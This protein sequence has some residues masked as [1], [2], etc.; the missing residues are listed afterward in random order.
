I[1]LLACLARQKPL[2]DLLKMPAK[3]GKLYSL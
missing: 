1:K 3:L 2:D